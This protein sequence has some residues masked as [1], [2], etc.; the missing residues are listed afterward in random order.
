MREGRHELPE[1][2]PDTGRIEAFSDGVFAIAMTLLVLDLRPPAPAAYG[3]GLA[4]LLLRQWPSYL[5]FV[6]SFAFIGIMWVNH[7]RLFTLIRRSDHTLLVLNGLVMLGVTVVPFPTALLAAYIGHRDERVAAIV[8]SGTYLAIAIFFYGLWRYA[9]HKHRLL[10]PRADPRAVEA[11]HRAYA[12]G[13]LLYL[14]AL[15][16][17]AVSVP[18][19]LAMNLALALFFALPPRHQVKLTPPQRSRKRN[20]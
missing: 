6:T 17:A 15:G 8:Y 2:A 4:T 18:A 1:D 13:P 19:S 16:F 20:V 7:H 14:I 10:D 3:P 9:S 5:A 11:I 12:H